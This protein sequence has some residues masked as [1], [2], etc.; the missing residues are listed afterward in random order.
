[1]DETC[2]HGSVILAAQWSG[3]T[4]QQQQQAYLDG[5]SAHARVYSWREGPHIHLRAGLRGRGARCRAEAAPLVRLWHCSIC[6]SGADTQVTQF[7]LR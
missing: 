5:R 1:M 2:S 6:N 4:T 3:N 7:K